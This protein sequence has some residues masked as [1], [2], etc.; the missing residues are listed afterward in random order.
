MDAL[1]ADAYACSGRRLAH[2]LPAIGEDHV[3]KEAYGLARHAETLE[4]LGG[5]ADVVSQ[6]AGSGA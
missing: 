5:L 6:V 2:P 1:L 4:D 3:G